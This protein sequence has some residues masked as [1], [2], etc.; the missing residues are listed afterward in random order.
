MELNSLTIPE[1]LSRAAKNAL[2]LQQYHAQMRNAVT[3]GSRIPPYFTPEQMRH[4]CE[5]LRREILK[6]LQRI[7]K[8]SESYEF[9][10]KAIHNRV[11][12]A[13]MEQEALEMS[14]DI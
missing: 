7:N 8:L 9:L 11:Q 14:E 13:K 12:A 3:D 4:A 10:D 5:I 2:K 6:D 1:S